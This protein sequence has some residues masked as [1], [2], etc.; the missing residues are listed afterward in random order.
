V[1]IEGLQLSVS[2]RGPD[3]ACRRSHIPVLDGGMTFNGNDADRIGAVSPAASAVA[4]R[5]PPADAIP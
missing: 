5:L 4:R 1:K 2:P 3:Y